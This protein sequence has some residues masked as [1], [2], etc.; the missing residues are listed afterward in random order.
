MKTLYFDE[1]GYTGS[2]LTNSDQPYFCVGS[3]CFSDEE[4]NQL[5]SD[6]GLEEH[7]E[8]HF[9]K[10][11]NSQ[12]G[13]DL[14]LKVLNHPLI[15]KGHVKLGVA[16]KRYCIYAQMIDTI[17]ETMFNSFGFNLYEGR[18][19]LILA[20]A[21]YSFAVTYSNQELIKDFEKS[22]VKMMRKKRR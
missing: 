13:R 10:L 16:E 2:D 15:D 9:V 1:A 6:L 22:F 3:T 20:N 7:G 21:L 17:V 14:I 12:K 5:H 11:S 4:L 19:N 8:L 18:K